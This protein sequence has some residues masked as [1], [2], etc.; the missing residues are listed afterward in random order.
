MHSINNRPV[1]LQLESLEARVT[2]ATIATNAHDQPASA[3]NAFGDRVVVWR[4]QSSTFDTDIRARLVQR[5][6]RETVIQITNT[7]F[8]SEFEP[9]V[10]IDDAGNFYVSYTQAGLTDRNV[11]ITRYDVTRRSLQTVQIVGPNFVE[12]YDSHIACTSATY[13]NVVVSFTRETFNGQR[14]VLA[15]MYS[16]T[17][18][19]F[20]FDREI[21]VANS[22]Q[23][24]EYDS[25]VARVPVNPAAG[26][27]A[28]TVV[29]VRDGFNQ[30]DVFAKVYDR[31]GRLLNPLRQAD[32][33]LGIA[34]TRDIEVNPTIAANANRQFVVAWQQRATNINQFD[35]RARLISMAGI[36]DLVARD[37]AVG[38]QDDIAPTVT[39]RNNGTYAVSYRSQFPGTATFQ[40]N[41]TQVAGAQIATR[42]VFSG[43]Q[44]S[45]QGLVGL[46]SVSI[47]DNDEYD[48]YFTRP[49]GGTTGFALEQVRVPFV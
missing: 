42:T 4:H 23:F 48:I 41:L 8:N 45:F 43:V 33:A 7:P 17:T 10:C 49:A 5:N 27:P 46:A 9:D 22:T 38:S 12:E 15:R 3:S 30:V 19:G 39:L 11:F 24:A 1:R 35:I 14:D 44:P 20:R 47:F 29:Y 26:Q 25:D 31:D 40:V 2:P 32:P 37:I 13:G 36:P 6:G 16:F 18:R 21:L 34:T 28:F